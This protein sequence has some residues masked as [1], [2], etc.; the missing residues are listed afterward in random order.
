[1]TNTST[2]AYSIMILVLKKGSHVLVFLYVAGG[3]KTEVLSFV[4]L[5]SNIRKKNHERR[6]LHKNIVII[7]L[8]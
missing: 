3:G 7:S 1:M 4:G 2:K 8:Q 5:R 6:N